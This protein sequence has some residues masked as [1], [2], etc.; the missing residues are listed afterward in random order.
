MMNMID[1]IV[2]GVNAS[3]IAIADWRL[4]EKQISREERYFVGSQAEQ[5]RLVH[6]KKYSLTVYVDTVQGEQKFRGEATISIQPTLTKE[7]VTAKISQAAYA[8]SKSKNQWFELPGPADPKAI[9]PESTFASLP[10]DQRLEVVRTAFFNAEPKAETKS[11]KT[12]APTLANQAE[13]PAQIAHTNQMPRINSIEIFLAHEENHMLNSKGFSFSSDS[14]RGY[15]EF[16]VEADSPAGPVELFDDIEF[17]EPDNDR[18][19]QTLD[20]RLSEVRDRAVAVPLP[21]LK[22]IP[23]IVRGKEAEQLFFWFFHNS[24]TEMVYSKASSFAVGMNVQQNSGTDT[25][26]EPLTIWAEPFLTGLPSSTPFDVDGYPLERTLVLEKGVLKTLIGSVRHA[27]WLSV[28]RKGSFP[29]FSVEP[30]T[31]PLAEMHSEPYLEPVMFSDFRL[32]PVTGSFGAEMRLAYY[33]DGTKILPVTGGSISGSVPMLRTK[34]RC[35]VE[36][37]LASMSLCPIAVQ[38]QGISITGMEN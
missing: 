9:I 3:K 15:S 22:N 25:V 1:T 16:V 23:V 18:L 11:I 36:R 8:A 21:N 19:A 27:D 24:K 10:D 2:E 4:V 32:D 37:G 6:E 20:S 13:V 34:M 26:L 33:H 29:L 30:G 12:A 28:P 35:S 14:W 31:M 17:S 7:E 5:A 38:L